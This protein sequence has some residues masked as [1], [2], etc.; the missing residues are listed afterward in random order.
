[1]STQTQRTPR[2]AQSGPVAVGKVFSIADIVTKGPTLPNR[3][4]LHAGQG[5]G[6][7]SLVAYAHKPIFIMTRGETGLET[8]IQAG[9]LP[10]TPHF[11]EVGSWSELLGAL[12]FLRNG[13]HDYKTLCLDTANGAERLMHE[14]VCERDFGG[15]WSERGFLSYNKGYE[16]ALADWRG[17]LNEL[18]KLR[19]ERG[20]T[21]FMLLH[22]KI[23]PFR[24]PNGADYD[25]YLPE[26]SEK[27][28]GLTKGWLDN[29]LFG[30]F[31]V[32]VTAG[33]KEL[34]DSSKRGKAAERSA[35][36][37]YT[38]SDNPT[39]DAKNRLGLPAEI[40]MGDSAEQGW[41]NLAE[42]IKGS[43]KA[44]VTA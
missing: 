13:D 27:T 32:V 10:E 4:G 3:W 33:G 23:K 42:A 16:V 11:P 8:L 31:E 39:F 26:M 7:T 38:S 9:Q 22:T 20:M 41:K 24:N 34:L 12:T 18:D 25:K 2:L 5:F 19:A 21:I 6:K 35:R 1:M 36:L 40:E 14:Y 43:R 37:L 28:W 15:D 29:I 17:F 30:N 44:A